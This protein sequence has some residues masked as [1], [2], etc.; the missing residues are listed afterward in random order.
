MM[1]LYSEDVLTLFE[2]YPE[3]RK[4]LKNKFYHNTTVTNITCIQP[5]TFE[6]HYT[7][8][9]M[10]IEKEHK[11]LALTQAKEVYFLY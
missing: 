11:S 3:L 10:K 1:V 4:L 5:Y 7:T 8:V 9:C 6:I 2:R